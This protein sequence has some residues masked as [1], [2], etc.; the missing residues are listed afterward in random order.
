MGAGV[1]GEAPPLSI[2]GGTTVSTPAGRTRGWRRRE[3]ELGG[4]GG[5]QERVGRCDGSGGSRWRPE[6]ENL[7]AGA[8]GERGRQ[9]RF[10]AP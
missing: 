7:A 1:A 8:D 4:R 6:T 10:R 5:Y 2:C 3:G 9:W